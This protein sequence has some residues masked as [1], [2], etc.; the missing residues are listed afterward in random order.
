MATKKVNILILGG[1]AV[2]A[3]AALSLETGGLAEVTAVLRSNFKTVNE[4]GYIIDSVDHG[5]LTGWRPSR[6]RTQPLSGPA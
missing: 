3:I 6:S 1:G 5:K 4:K 2:G